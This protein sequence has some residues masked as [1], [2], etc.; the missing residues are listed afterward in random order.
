M[1]RVAEALTE[2]GITEWVLSDE[3]TT[4]DEFNKMFRKITGADEHGSAILSSNQADWGT[5]W[6]TVSAKLTALNAAEPLKLLREE[7]NRKIAETDW[8]AGSD[9]TMTD[10]QT[11]YRQA[12]RD[13]TDSATSLDDVTW[14]TKP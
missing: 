2:L 10:A 9:L 1:T 13:I 8:W 5:D 14:P 12:L 3:P 4:E 11:T 7:R 6:A